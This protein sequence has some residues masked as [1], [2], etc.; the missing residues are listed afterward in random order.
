MSHRALGSRSRSTAADSLSREGR[1]KMRFVRVTA[2][3]IDMVA[4]P[5]SLHMDLCIDE[6]GF[7]M[8][9]EPIFGFEGSLRSKSGKCAPF[10]LYENGSLDYGDEIVDVSSATLDIRS[11]P[12][13]CGTRLELIYN[14]S[15]RPFTITKIRSRLIESRDHKE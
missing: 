15:A 14:G 12:L 13:V 2:N 8:D 10:V 9:D 7:V 11:K 6:D 4:S 5:S 1:S 3:S